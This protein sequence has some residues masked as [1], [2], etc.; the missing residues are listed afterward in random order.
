MSLE[1]ESID[2]HRKKIQDLASQ[3]QQPLSTMTEATDRLN[4]LGKY[5]D[6]LTAFTSGQRDQIMSDQAARTA[7]S[8]L[9]VVWQANISALRR[10]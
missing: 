8:E 2:F 3:M 9:D 7:W 1:Q 6:Y 4:E 10:R 5:V